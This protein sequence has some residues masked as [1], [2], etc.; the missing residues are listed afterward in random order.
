[1]IFHISHGAMLDPAD[2]SK[3]EWFLVKPLDGETHPSVAGP[4]IT[5]VEAVNSLIRAG[6]TVFELDTETM[7]AMCINEKGVRHHG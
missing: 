4:P 6:R 2:P 7:S 5:H 1:M 3:R